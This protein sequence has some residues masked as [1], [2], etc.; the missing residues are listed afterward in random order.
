[1]LG[2]LLSALVI[3]DDRLE[4]K[5][6]ILRIQVILYHVFKLRRLLRI[7]LK[8]G[9]H[10][11]QRKD[12]LHHRVQL[13]LFLCLGLW[14]QLMCVGALHAVTVLKWGNL[15]LWLGGASWATHVLSGE[16]RRHAVA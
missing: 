2:L 8:Y 10:L 3:L 9:L 15:H 7:L 1:M 13:L 12:L 16:Y 11:W 4:Y 6:D 5:C 14:L